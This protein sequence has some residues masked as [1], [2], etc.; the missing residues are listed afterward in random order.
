MLKILFETVDKI[1]SCLNMPQNVKGVS[2]KVYIYPCWRQQAHALFATT[3]F[4]SVQQMSSL[5]AHHLKEVNSGVEN[6]IK[7]LTVTTYV[8]NKRFLGC[9]VSRILKMVEVCLGNHSR[10][11][12]AQDAGQL[13]NFI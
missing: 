8:A 4:S 6:G 2:K 3:F 12:D 7:T 5:P 11:L 13:P 10:N 9:R 1:Q